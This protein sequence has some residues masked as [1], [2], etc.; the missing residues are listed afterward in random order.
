MACVDP[1]QQ[2]SAAATKSANEAS[3]R[4]WR[5][6]TLQRLVLGK[7]GTAMVL[8][9]FFCLFFFK[10]HVYPDLSSLRGT[11]WIPHV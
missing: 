10:K 3:Q 4:V 2:V 8:G 1:G 11:E 9:F 7:K 6:G 5:G